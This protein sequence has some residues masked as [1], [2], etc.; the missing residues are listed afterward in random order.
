MIAAMGWAERGLRSAENGTSAGR[1]YY[2]GKATVEVL[3]LLRRDASGL[4][5]R[6]IVLYQG[7]SRPIQVR[8]GLCA[9]GAVS[10]SAPQEG[11]GYQSKFQIKLRRPA[12]GGQPP[13]MGKM[14]YDLCGWGPQVGCVAIG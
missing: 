7:S 1:R 10:K 3:S 6:M 9:I 14:R 4:T 13:P 5:G 12:R 2:G 8:A 11:Q